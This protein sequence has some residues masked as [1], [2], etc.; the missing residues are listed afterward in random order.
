MEKKTQELIDQINE[1]R[2]VDDSF[3]SKFQEALNMKVLQCCQKI[4]EQMY[5]IYEEN[6]ILIHEN[7]QELSQVLKRI[8]QLSNELQQAS[9]KIASVYKSFCVQPEL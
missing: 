4:E 1:N 8:S 6:N 7:M 3:W 5:G 9:Q 2:K